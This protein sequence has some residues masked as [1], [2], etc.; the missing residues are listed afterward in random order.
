MF[1]Q[2][3]NCQTVFRVTATMLKAAQ[4]RVRCG[5]CDFVFNALTFLREP[6]DAA[7]GDTPGKAGPVSTPA[8]A[9]TV[10]S[11]PAPSSSGQPQQKKRAPDEEMRFDDNTGLDDEEDE[12]DE[13]EDDLDEL[14]SDDDA[15]ADESEDEEI[16]EGIE[17]AEATGGGEEIELA[18]DAQATDEADDAD[19]EELELDETA[20][21]VQESDIPESELEF[22]ADD[23]SKVFVLESAP[24][25]PKPTGNRRGDAAHDSPPASTRPAAAPVVSTGSDRG[26][27]IADLDDDDDTGRHEVLDIELEGSTSSEEITLEGDSV[28]LEGDG[29]VPEE[30]PPATFAPPPPATS[31]AQ[32][33]ATSATTSPATPVT[34]IF[35]PTQEAIDAEVQR[36]IEAAFAADPATRAEFI[37]PSGRRMEIGGGAPSAETGAADADDT[38]PHEEL[39][40]Q[41][42]RQQRVM[43]GWTVA[44]GV[45]AFTLFLQLI[46]HNR[47]SLVKNAAIGPAL[48]GVYNTFGSEVLPEWNLQAYELRQ[49]GAAAD[50]DA[51]GTLRVRAS[52]LNGAVYAQP[53]PVLRLTLQDRFGGQVGRRDLQPREYLR[54]APSR[55]ALIGAGQRI[56]ADIAIVDPGKDAV[57]FE[58]DVCLPAAAQALTCAGEGG[59]NAG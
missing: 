40:A 48:T 3:P 31:A 33:P 28:V 12:E 11:A 43:L 56:D 20:I 58:I 13:E 30:G 44:S 49:Y 51:Q 23:L 22:T 57:G 38:D 47:Q 59:R 32:S 37:L 27:N 29:V 41:Q 19:E 46:H 8:S 5:R 6:E 26:V 10:G 50:A 54:S 53:Y 36:E 42:R 15:D 24:T 52:L 25:R 55:S 34:K 1:T 35:S 21:E 4:G 14:D 18:G 17:L 16:V 9:K 39:A 2:C 7:A 45:L